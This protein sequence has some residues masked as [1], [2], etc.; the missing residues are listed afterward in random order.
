[1]VCAMDAF[2]MSITRSHEEIIEK[3]VYDARA[4]MAKVATSTGLI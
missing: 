4:I 2:A 1:M 3:E